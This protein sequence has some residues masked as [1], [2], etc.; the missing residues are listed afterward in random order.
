MLAGLQGIK[1]QL[2]AAVI[3]ENDPGRFSEIELRKIGV[4]RLPRALDQALNA[5]QHNETV[6]TWFPQELLDIYLRH[7]RQEIELLRHLSMD[8]RCAKYRQ[9]Y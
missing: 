1:E 7:K 8:E 6:R 5:L 3:M 9:V 4:R 2:P